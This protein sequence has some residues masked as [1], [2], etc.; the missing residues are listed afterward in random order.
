MGRH[1][2]KKPRRERSTPSLVEEPSKP[3]R[4]LFDSSDPRIEVFRK[5][6]AQLQADIEPNPEDVQ[7]LWDWHNEDSANNLVH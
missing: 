5:V 6:K 1:K 2:A 4:L 7:L 3:P